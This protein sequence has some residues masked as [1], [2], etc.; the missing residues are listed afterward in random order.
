MKQTKRKKTIVK[1][2]KPK[3]VKVKK[4]TAAQP[5]VALLG[6]ENIIGEYAILFQE[7]GIETAN[8]KTLNADAK[9]ITSALELT[10][11]NSELKKKNLQLLDKL[12][13]PHIPII[14]SSICVTITEQAEW[15]KNKER[16]IG[17]AAFPTLIANSLIELSPS[18]YTAKTTADAVQIFFSTIKKET[19]LVQDSVGMVMPRI[20]CQVV[21][22]AF[23]AIQQDIAQPNDIDEALSSAAQFPF[24]PIEWSEKIGFKNIVAVLDALYNNTKEERYRVSPLLRQ[25]ENAGKFWQSKS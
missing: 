21:N 7:N 16:F 4:E 5:C 8:E 13:A 3:T 11:A 22:E 2:K 25:M 24:G 20:L 9:K 23:F 10:L 18:I 12:L 14:S 19:A 17:I 6:D 1:N 15:I